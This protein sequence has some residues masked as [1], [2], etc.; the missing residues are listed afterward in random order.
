MFYP[1]KA[2]RIDNLWLELKNHSFVYFC[3][4]L[5]VVTYGRHHCVSVWKSYL[6][7]ICN[8]ACRAL[9]D[10]VCFKHK[11]CISCL[12]VQLRDH[13]NE[14]PFGLFQLSV[15]TFHLKFMLLLITVQK[16]IAVNL[17]YFMYMGTVCVLFTL[18]RSLEFIFLLVLT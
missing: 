8:S 17:F 6:D 18:I 13:K 15:F 1:T 5:N 3:V 12:R 4:N 7:Y 2:M 16:L 11:H 9:P 10:I 14:R